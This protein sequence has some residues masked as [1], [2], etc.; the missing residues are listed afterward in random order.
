MNH[1]IEQAYNE[2]NSQKQQS[3]PEWDRDI[4]NQF[5]FSQN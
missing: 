4:N 1:S 2:N 5:Q 3:N